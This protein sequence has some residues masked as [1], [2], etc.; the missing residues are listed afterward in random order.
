MHR[1]GTPHTWTKDSPPARYRLQS[2]ILVWTV[3]PLLAVNAVWT[4]GSRLPQHHYL[5]AELAIS[6]SF[7]LITLLL[8]AATP[9]AAACGGIICLLLTDWSISS[10]PSLLYSGLPPLAVLFVLT[11]AATRFGR[12]R[13]DARGL[14]ESRTGRR[15]SQVIANL[16]VAALCTAFNHSQKSLN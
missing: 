12:A 5:L 16:G 7:A 2:R 11:F 9:G 8:K 14:S 1:D 6:L 4:I 10:P 13:K 15:T 3:A